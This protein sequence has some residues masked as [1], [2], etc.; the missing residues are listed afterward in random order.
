MRPTHDVGGV[1]ASVADLFVV[2][3]QGAW[4][5]WRSHP[6][7]HAVL[8]CDVLAR[9]GFADGSDQPRYVEEPLVG[10]PGVRE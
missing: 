3:A 2:A 8:Q 5:W 10:A 9:M 4:R 7:A 1:R 6:P